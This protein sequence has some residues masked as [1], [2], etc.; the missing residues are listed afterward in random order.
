M[1]RVELR[2]QLRTLK[3]LKEEVD[4]MCMREEQGRRA[5][6]MDIVMAKVTKANFE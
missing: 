4:E 2:V 3:Y 6:L 5:H 1:V